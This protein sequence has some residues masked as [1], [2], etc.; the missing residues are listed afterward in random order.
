MN[1]A[2]ILALRRVIALLANGGQNLL[3]ASVGVQQISLSS[4]MSQKCC[5]RHVV[6]EQLQQ[7]RSCGGRQVDWCRCGTSLPCARRRKVSAAE[8]VDVCVMHLSVVSRH[9]WRNGAARLV[10][11]RARRATRRRKPQRDGRG[12]GP[13]SQSGC[14]ALRVNAASAAS[15]DMVENICCNSAPVRGA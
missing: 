14:L 11:N 6:C 9:G 2:S 12:P 13:M 3:C 8:S 7:R 5:S 4:T 15:A 1:T 10:S